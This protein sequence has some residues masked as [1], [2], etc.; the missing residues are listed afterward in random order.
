MLMV[1]ISYL[2]RDI[3]LPHSLISQSQVCSEG[4]VILQLEVEST[5]GS[6]LSLS[7]KSFPELNL[8]KLVHT[9][10]I[11]AL[12]VVSVLQLSFIS[13]C[14][15]PIVLSFQQILALLLLGPFTCQ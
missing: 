10:V 5:D 9:L 2:P 4:S 3:F 11:C 12:G 13:P 1:C 15:Y 6:P 7:E 8:P 14:F